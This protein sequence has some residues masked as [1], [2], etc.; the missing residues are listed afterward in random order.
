[1]KQLILFLPLT[2]VRICKVLLNLRHKS[3]NAIIAKNPCLQINKNW[4]NLYKNKLNNRNKMNSFACYTRSH[5]K[6]FAFGTTKK[7]AQ[8]APYLASIEDMNLKV[9]NRFKTKRINAI[10]KYFKFSSKKNKSNK[11]CATKKPN[12]AWYKFWIGS[13]T[14]CKKKCG[15]NSE[16]SESKSLN[17]KKPFLKSYTKPTNLLKRK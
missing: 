7:Y 9:F 8:N 3:F 10:F 15:N 14:S 4:A 11:E 17:R 5:L 12:V 2:N 6:L 1:M 13:G 16:N